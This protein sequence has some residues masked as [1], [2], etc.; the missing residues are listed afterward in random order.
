MAD[1]TSDRAAFIALLEALGNARDAMRAI[2]LLRSDE[3][4]IMTSRVMDKTKDHVTHLMSAKPL[5]ANARIW[6]PGQPFNR[7]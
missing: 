7:N 5:A 6:M 1:L 2:G 3:R 4:W